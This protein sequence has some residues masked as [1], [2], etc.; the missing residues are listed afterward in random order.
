MHPHQIVAVEFL[1]NRLVGPSSSAPPPVNSPNVNSAALVTGS[2]TFD[3]DLDYIFDAKSEVSSSEDE[4]ESFLDPNT[5]AVLE[6]QRIHN[7]KKR[8][9]HAESGISPPFKDCRGAV[10]ADEMGLGKSLVS[11]AVLWH[12]VN[13]GEKSRKPLKHSLHLHM[14]LCGCLLLIRKSK[15][16]YCVSVVSGR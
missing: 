15:G 5:I 16:D 1:L 8:K 11:I 3:H 13:H 6:K 12:F 4:E 9:L 2:T 10:L 7:N 14:T